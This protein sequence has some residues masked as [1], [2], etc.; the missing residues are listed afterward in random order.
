MQYWEFLL[1]REGDRAWLPLE[2][3]AVEILE[4]HY[5]IAARSSRTNASVEVRLT[6]KGSDPIPLQHRLQKRIGK[7]NGEGLMAVWPYTQLKPGLWELC[8]SSELMSDF[9]G[10]GW[11]HTLQLQVLPCEGDE[12]GLLPHEPELAVSEVS[13]PVPAESLPVLTVD[14]L[15]VPEVESSPTETPDAV[16]VFTS[17]W[18]DQPP[19]DSTASS[20]GPL[21]VRA[22]E[23]P[24]ASALPILQ[25]SLE[26][27]AYHIQAGDSITVAGAIDRLME[28]IES[29]ATETFDGELQVCLFSPEDD[30]ILVNV[31]QPL[32]Q[33]TLPL[34]FRCTI[35]IPPDHEE[36]SILGEVRVL[37]QQPLAM[38]VVRGFA[39]AVL[40]DEPDETPSPPEPQ[41]LT[42]LVDLSPKLPEL[43]PSLNLSLLDLVNAPRPSLP[44]SLQN[45]GLQ[46][47][48][49]Q[50]YHPDP[51]RSRTPELPFLPK[52]STALPAPPA[53]TDTSP[54]DIPAVPQ[55]PS[56]ER[57]WSRLNALVEG[58][59][60]SEEKSEPSETPE[61]L[62]D[63]G[64]L[65]AWIDEDSGG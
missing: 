7:T 2:S 63:L 4:G 36:Q 38:T 25:I 26:Q 52:M 12:L 28:G 16:P 64:G 45:L 44:S 6:Y 46:P 15:S 14:P 9:F 8:C 19:F 54:E 55:S 57:F 17:D 51:S 23:A 10:E 31:Q 37:M 13:L 30:Q 65:E 58:D 53:L 5:R 48:P 39:I 1:Q 35:T 61:Q 56:E 50:I 21:P 62:E 18:A 60:N 34:D 42:S 27:D 59:E 3:S 24:L 29:M 43:R 11:Q 33:A 32:Q 49:D 41:W 47:L 22:T 20:A 40:G